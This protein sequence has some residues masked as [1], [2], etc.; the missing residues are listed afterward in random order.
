MTTPSA[1]PPAAA[2]QGNDRLLFGM[3]AGLV[4]FWLFAQTM[5]NVAPDMRRDLGVASGT[6]NVAVS[7]TSLFSG[8]FNIGIGAGALLGSQIGMH[9]GLQ[10]LG[11]VGGSIALVGV[12]WCAYAGWQWRSSFAPAGAEARIVPH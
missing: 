2:F 6:M 5:L 1:A 12:L 7:L 3:I 9:A 10:Y 4:T 11:P 8:I